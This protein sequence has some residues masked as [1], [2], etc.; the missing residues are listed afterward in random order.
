[1]KHIY[2]CMAMLMAMIGYGQSF[3]KTHTVGTN[4]YELGM[5][6]TP[7]NWGD[8]YLDIV[9]KNTG[10]TDLDIRN[11]VIRFLSSHAA[12][13]RSVNTNSNATFPEVSIDHKAQG[14][15]TINS[16]LLSLTTEDWVDNIL[17][18]N[19]TLNLS[20]NLK[21]V[22]SGS[23]ESIA[24]DMR[25][26]PESEVPLLFVTVNASVSGNDGE[27]VTI[28]YKNKVTDISGQLKTNSSLEKP[29]RVNQEYAIWATDFVS[30]NS[31]YT[32]QYTEASPLSF[33]PSTSNK[34]VTVAFTKSAAD[35][36]S[37]TVT[38]S[39][40]PNGV[41]TPITLKNKTN[42]SITYNSTITNGSTTI[43]NVLKGEYTVTL[44]R[45]AENN[46]LYTPQYTETLTVGNASSLEV[47]YTASDL[48]PFTVKGF[49]EYLAQGTIT[50]ASESIDGNFKSP[51]D[52]LFKYSGIDGAGDRGKIPSM[53]PAK[54]T[55]EQARRLEK[56][57]PGRKILPVM[58]HYT[59]NASGGGSLEAIKDIDEN[60]NLY[61]HYRN[62]IQEI[63]TILSYEDA[64]HPNPGAFVISPDLIGAIQQ[65]VVFGN[66]HDITTMQIDV[67]EDIAK[68]FK[69]EN[70]DISEIP[71]FTDD[72]KGYF[73]SINYTIKHVGECKIPFGY[74]ENVWAAGSALWVFENAN[75]ANDA[76]S[77]AIEV[78]NFI[79]SLEL[80]T[81]EWKPDFIAFDRYER[82]CFGPD[83]ILNY[84]WTAK[85]WDKYLVFC[86]EIAERIGDMPIMLWQIPAGHMVT[87]DETITNYSISRHSSAAAPYFLGDDRIGTNLNNIHADVRNIPLTSGHYNVSS[88]GELLAKDGNY[89]WSKSNLQRLADMKVFSILWGGGSTTGVAAI[90]TNGDDDGWMAN[91]ITKYYEN[92][93]YN[94]KEAPTYTIPNAC[95]GV[96]NLEESVLE[97]SN[98]YVYPNPVTDKLYASQNTSFNDFSVQVYDITGRII[99]KV[100]I[101]EKYIDV[102][103]LPVGIYVIKINTDNNQNI[104]AKFIKE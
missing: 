41:A 25:F 24:N 3:T 71:T 62:L 49:P 45:V 57:Q 78:A 52:V 8:V 10:T 26:Y 85:H 91:K 11:S 99:Q 38:V 60:E 56:K 66:D 61:Y 30:G 70:I 98:I 93:V 14:E 59:A 1:M 73:Q 7:Q 5:T 16:A 96:L 28:V 83:A 55:I 19:E 101:F 43:E 4:T 23:F 27:M 75:E 103:Q 21:A 6:F 76:V 72:L 12:V 46:S 102:S 92:V 74:Q 39:G 44:N 22:D 58:V 86:K 53:I 104:I 29:L 50:S 9:L 17:A 67:N 36:A 79:N 69:D 63:K 77:E 89:D 68:A 100:N 65:D 13:Y 84:A 20:L 51:L 35:V 88:V 97:T 33:T 82:D 81:G 31:Y 18:T 95:G 47:T 94:T 90:G 54:N 42:H 87:N 34:N 15:Q 80:Y 64:E 2:F 32:S 48:F 37:V 40:L